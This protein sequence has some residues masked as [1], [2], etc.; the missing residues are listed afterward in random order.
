[1][2]AFYFSVLII[3]IGV[4]YRYLPRLFS[5]LLMAL[6]FRSIYLSFYGLPEE[7]KEVF[8]P[9][10]LSGLE[11]ILDM[12]WLF[13]IVGLGMFIYKS[14]IIKNNSNKKVTEEV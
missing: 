4:F 11:M 1:M 9:E 3:M 8:S 7:I 2:S 14:N 5:L 12:S 13:I 6:G 10:S